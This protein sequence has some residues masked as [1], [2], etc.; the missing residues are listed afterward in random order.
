MPNR[1]IPT[2]K[3]KRSKQNIEFY[4]KVDILDLSSWILFSNRSKQCAEKPQ[5]HLN[6]VTGD[7]RE[8]CAGPFKAFEALSHMA[9][10]LNKAYS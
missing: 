7:T 6:T 3:P 8:M 5:P 1:K 9:K 4:L 10:A 2:N